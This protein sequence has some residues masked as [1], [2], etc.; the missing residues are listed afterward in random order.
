MKR[1]KIRAFP[2][3]SPLFTRPVNRQAANLLKRVNDAGSVKKRGP[4]RKC[5][6]CGARKLGLED[7]IRAK[8]PDA[9]EIP[10]SRVLEIADRALTVPVTP[11]S[12]KTETA[13]PC[14]GK[15]FLR[16]TSH[17]RVAHPKDSARCP[18]PEC[19][20]WVAIARTGR[21]TCP[22]CRKRFTV[23]PRFRVIGKRLSCPFCRG[24]MY[25][26]RSGR[27]RCRSCRKLIRVR[28]D[29]LPCKRQ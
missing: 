7:H 1:V 25:N 18:Y 4:K 14:C 13:C 28:K 6:Y 10:D 16:L 21:I 26:E 9:I 24:L 23:S 15:P 22:S 3:G 19:G 5:P 2:W 27:I 17:M 20:A 8:H 12:P 29:F 11:R